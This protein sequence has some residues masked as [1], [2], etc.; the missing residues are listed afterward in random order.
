M[1]AI[2][3]GV[4]IC[5]CGDGIAS[6]LD[7]DT[8]ERGARDLPGVTTARRLGYSCSPDGLA[9]IQAAIGKEG[10]N[11]VLVAGCTPRTLEPRFQAACA[12]DG[13]DD[14]MFELVDIREGCAWVHQGEPQ[15][16]TAKALDLIR[17][18]V[19]RVALRQTRHPVS[20]KVTPAALVIGGG[21]TGMTAALTLATAGQPVKLVER[22]TALGGMLRDVYSLN[23]DR[24]NAAEFVAQKVEAVTHHPRVEVLLES[25]VTDI[26]GTVGRYT[27]GV[28]GA[29]RQ[30]D[31]GAIVVATG[32]QPLRPRGL[33]RYDGKRV[34]TQLEFER[35]LRDAEANNQSAS[36]PVSNVVMILC[37]GRHNGAIPYCSGVCCP[38]AVKQALEIKAANPRANATILFRDLNL[39]GENV[40]EERLIEARRAGV[41]F[42]R[43]I[44]SSP[45]EVTGEVVEVHDE[46]TGTDRRLPYDRIVLATPLVPQPDAS[47]VAHMLGIAQDENG[48]FPEVRYRLRPQNYAE[49]GIYV[50]GAAHY[51]ADWTEGEFQATSA[52]FK[53]LRHLRVGQVTS[54]APV[55]VVDEKLCTGC[56]TCV[57]VCP[58]GAISMHQREGELDLSQIDPLL[59]TGCG[60]CVVVCPVKAISQPLDS[61]GQVLAQIEAALATAARNGRPRILVFGCEWSGHAAGELAGAKKLRYP[62]EARLIRVGCSA[63]IDPTH[64]L[65]AFFSGA[66]GVFLGA[67]PPGDCHYVNG[68]LHAQERFNTLRNL[69]GKSGFDPRRLRLEWITPDDPHDFVDKI[70]DFTNLMTALGPSPVSGG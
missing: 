1:S 32:A 31:V 5:D 13:L 70:M 59:C 69:L 15:A 9:A 14:G 42:I 46:L 68:N 55:A 24:R 18:G 26:S 8:L 50:C 23:P 36:L 56:G 40:Y 48:F 6:I 34:V 35:E 12:E 16:A 57:K 11:R 45:P 43:Y 25:Q 47:V 19:A 49:R 4:F 22:E 67:C 53:T 60:S 66:D 17:M 63:R 20:A 62:A 61:D 27:V 33:F 39:L 51:P 52:A 30:F 58:F 38:G 10:L 64:V 3:L 37:A 29:G 41:E 65:W 21:V 28:N 2:R 44:P 7:M 54:H